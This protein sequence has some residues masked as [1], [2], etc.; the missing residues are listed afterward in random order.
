[1]KKKIIILIFLSI[2]LICSF[3]FLFNRNLER[4]IHV[5]DTYQYLAIYDTETINVELTLV[6]YNNIF[7]N[8]TK[9]INISFTN[10]QS[11]ILNMPKYKLYKLDD[12]S[13]NTSIY[14][15]I[16]ELNGEQTAEQLTEY[17]KIEI[18][19]GRRI[20]KSSI[21]S[22]NI[23][24]VQREQIPK[25]LNIMATLFSVDGSSY[26][27]VVENSTDSNLIIN[28]IYYKLNYQHKVHYYNQNQT[29]TIPK[30][31]S[32]NCDYIIDKLL[33]G[34]HVIIRPIIT[35]SYKNK[36][37]HTLSHAPIYFNNS[38]SQNEINSLSR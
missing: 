20:Y 18:H 16:F 21:G 3:N 6:D 27:I 24:K 35:F 32:K 33:S 22:I 9:D 14:K 13:K 34:K 36:E 17:T 2:A 26:S 12:L 19:K 28:D 5:F 1:M 4:D 38:I 25:N 31:S 23:Q 29:I 8:A 30:N 7:D 11:N 15:I 10:K 37:Y